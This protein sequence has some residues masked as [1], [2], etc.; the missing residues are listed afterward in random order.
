VLTNFTEII[1]DDIP[2]WA[3]EAMEDGQLWNRV[4]EK[5]AKLQKQVTTLEAINKEMYE[6]H[7]IELARLHAII[8]QA[9]YHKD[10]KNE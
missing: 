1:P 7:R 3:R 10:V 6:N 4:F 9:K 2:D 5:I 8:D